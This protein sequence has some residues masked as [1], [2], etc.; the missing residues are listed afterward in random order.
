MPINFRGLSVLPPNIVVTDSLTPQVINS[1]LI[2][3]GVSF[4]F[5][6]REYSPLAVGAIADGN[7]HPLSSQ[8]STL[9]SA[10]ADFPFVTSLSQ[11]LDW[12][13][14]QKAFNAATGTPNGQTPSVKTWKGPVNLHSGIYRL[15]GDYWKIQSVIGTKVTGDGPS[16][17]SIRGLSPAAPALL[18]VDGSLNGLFEGFSFDTQDPTQIPPSALRLWWNQAGGTVRSTS[19]NIFRNVN[20]T[21][22]SGSGGFIQGFELAGSNQVDASKWFACQVNLG[23]LSGNTSSKQ[24]GWL[25]GNGTPANNKN[26]YFYDCDVVTLRYGWNCNAS[27]AVVYG[28]AGGG[29]EVDFY[30]L[31]AGGPCLLD[32]FESEG[33]SRLLE[34]LSGST[35][36]VSIVR[37][38]QFNPVSTLASDGGW[39]LHGGAGQ[40]YVQE[41]VCNPLGVTANTAC[42]LLSLS[43]APTTRA[44]LIGVRQPSTIA[45]GIQTINGTGGKVIALNYAELNSLGQITQVTP[46]Y[47]L[48]DNNRL[49]VT[50]SRGSNAALASLLTDLANIGMIVDSST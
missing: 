10:Q 24:S 17:C 23:W 46:F 36:S 33:S 47:I 31:G 30:A 32:G 5:S 29:N 13:A 9:A 16:A 21:C 35:D 14:G 42:I 37:G 6:S 8:Y 7:P 26:H 38:C 19:N 1:K 12:A 41:T 50:G 2:F 45:T 49:T 34:R 27:N 3:K 15:D 4:F 20:V 43:G 40:L 11:Q 22:P 48:N 39:I 44:L 25:L 18:D 28:G